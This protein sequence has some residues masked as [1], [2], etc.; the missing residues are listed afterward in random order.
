MVLPCGN[1]ANL[2]L[3]WASGNGKRT[4]ALFPHGVPIAPIGGHTV[5]DRAC[6]TCGD[7][8]GCWLPG[9]LKK[10]EPELMTKAADAIL[11]NDGELTEWAISGCRV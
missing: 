1:S 8:N 5:S 9:K 11:I 6:A 3:G 10:I 7:L 2:E 4:A